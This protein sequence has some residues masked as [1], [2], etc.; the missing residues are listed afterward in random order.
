MTLT[1]NV[2]C[3]ASVR[4]DEDLIRRLI[5]NLLDNALKYGSDCGTVEIALR[6]DGGGHHVIVSDSGPGIP[7]EM[8]AHIFD[9]FYRGDR[10]RTSYSA[11]QSRLDEEPH[12]VGAGLGLAIARW[13]AEAHGGSL[14]LAHSSPEGSE[15]V[16]SLPDT[17]S[18]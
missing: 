5:L 18:G 3:E 6:C 13:I 9:R 16:F 1:S 8:A 10:S 14:V 15:F 12:G 11:A 7:L 2:S 17:S 4:G